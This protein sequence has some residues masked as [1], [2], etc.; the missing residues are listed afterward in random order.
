MKKQYYNLGKSCSDRYESPLMV[1]LLA[2]KCVGICEE[3]R[4]NSVDDTEYFGDG[5]ED[6]L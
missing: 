5:G 1:V 6:N 4:Y 3:S 2:D